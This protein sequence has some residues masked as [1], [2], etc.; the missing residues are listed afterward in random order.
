MVC[1]K[2]AAALMGFIDFVATAPAAYGVPLDDVKNC[3]C[4]DVTKDYQTSDPDATKKACPIY[5]GVGSQVYVRRGESQGRIGVLY[6]YYV[7]KVRWAEGDNNGHRH[8]WASVVVWI[9]RWG[10]ETDDI[11]ALWPVGVSYT[12]DHL[13]WGSAAAGS[14]SFKS[15]DV[16]INMDKHPKMQIHDNTLSPFTGADGD[17]VFEPTLYEKTQVPFTDDN[18]QAHLDAA[19]R[20]DFYGGIPTEPDCHTEEPPAKTDTPDDPPTS[21]T[22][23]TQANPTAL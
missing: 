7:P 5:G 2:T 3:Y 21:A 13:S 22:S 14:V 16:G 9:N 23:A 6:S 4:G 15:S 10:C 19:Y 18:F 17:S 11:T 1:L 20:K 12:T 8:Y